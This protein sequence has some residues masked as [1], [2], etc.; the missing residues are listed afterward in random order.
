MS[1][2][3][4]SDG[5]RRNKEMVGLDWANAWDILSKYWIEQFCVLAVGAVAWLYNKK[6]KRYV[7]DQQA[8]KMAMLA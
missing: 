5:K 3:Y 2:G 6:L 7:G 1:P 8:V 4:H